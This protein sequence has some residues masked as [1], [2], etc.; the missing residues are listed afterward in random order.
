[1]RLHNTKIL[2][3]GSRNKS[4]RTHHR[5]PHSVNPFTS[6]FSLSGNSLRSFRSF[7]MFPVGIQ[8]PWEPKINRDNKESIYIYDQKQEVKTYQTKTEKDLVF[9][10][11]DHQNQKQE[12]NKA[13]ANNRNNH[14]INSTQSLK[15]FKCI[16]NHLPIKSNIE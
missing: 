2:Q 3:I 14:S 6:L 4:E 13:N 10:V 1:M 11:Q 8:C 5:I 15:S 7:L 12:E 9:E 16:K